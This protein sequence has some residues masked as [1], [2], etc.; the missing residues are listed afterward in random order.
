MQHGGGHVLDED[1]DDEV[2]NLKQDWT[3]ERKLALQICP[4]LADRLPH[5]SRF[6]PLKSYRE[7]HIREKKAKHTT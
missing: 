5:F 4:K 1:W 6:E 2:S 3:E 7:E